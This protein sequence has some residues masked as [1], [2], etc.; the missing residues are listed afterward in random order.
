MTTTHDPYGS[1]VRNA[2]P[3]ATA[4]ENTRG[5]HDERIFAWKTSVGTL[6]LTTQL[7]MP[8]GDSCPSTLSLALDGVRNAFRSFHPCNLESS[9]TGLRAAL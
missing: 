3:S 9:L 6:T 1:S 5:P 2:F 4:L 8:S 7:P